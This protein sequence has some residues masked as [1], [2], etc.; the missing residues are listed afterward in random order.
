MAT[1]HI[2]INVDLSVLFIEYFYQ[3][4]MVWG[5]IQLFTF[6]KIQK[7]LEICHVKVY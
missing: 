2:K 7:C 1:S 4:T 5:D 6:G 3:I